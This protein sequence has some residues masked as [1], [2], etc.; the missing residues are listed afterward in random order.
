MIRDYGMCD[1]EPPLVQ[2]SALLQT[3]RDGHLTLNDVLNDG[4]PRFPTVP[5]SHINSKFDSTQKQYYSGVAATNSYSLNPF[6]V[7]VTRPLFL[8]NA[9]VR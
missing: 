2:D 5:F 8:T 3:C 1:V 9:E 7:N 4:M 6:T